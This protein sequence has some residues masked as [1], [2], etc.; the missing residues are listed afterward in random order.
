MVC[1]STCSRSFPKAQIS[2][3]VSFPKVCELGRE[4]TVSENLSVSGSSL[5]MRSREVGK[6]ASKGHVCSP[7]AG[8]GGSGLG[9]QS[10]AHVSCWGPPCVSGMRSWTIWPGKGRCAD[11]SK[12]AHVEQLQAARPGPWSCRRVARTSKYSSAGQWRQ[13]ERHQGEGRHH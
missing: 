8:R 9:G 6:S 1:R 10:G 11:G 13:V 2:A 12:S 3:Q 7:P 4:E 5:G